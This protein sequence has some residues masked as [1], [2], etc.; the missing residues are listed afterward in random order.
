MF[1]RYKH[2]GEEINS[3]LVFIE[4]KIFK[5]EGGFKLFIIEFLNFSSGKVFLCS[6]LKNTNAK[7]I[8]FQNFNSKIRKICILP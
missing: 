8:G 4:F 1:Y 7:N 3:D 2:N 5:V 6:Y